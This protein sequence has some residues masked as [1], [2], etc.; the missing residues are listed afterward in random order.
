MNNKMIYK[1]RFLI[2]ALA[3]VT[4][5]TV[6]AKELV[7]K[8]AI[9]ADTQQADLKRNIVIFKNNVDIYHNDKNIKADL[10]EVHRRTE[11]GKEK[12][13]LIATGNPATFSGK[14]KDGK[15]VTASAKN[16][17]YDVA[18]GT[19]TFNGNAKINQSGQS[20]SAKTIVYDHKQELITA[21]K[22]K[23][24]D[25]RVHTILTPVKKDKR[26]VKKE[27]KDNTGNN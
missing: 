17:R 8:V 16:I 6:H 15:P 12:Q 26:P 23:G 18:A 4:N 27:E 11:L 7:G 22:D 24:S 9:S 20:M 3:L 10:L 25:Q 19:L 5:F 2:A 14:L 1:K 13:L 21:N